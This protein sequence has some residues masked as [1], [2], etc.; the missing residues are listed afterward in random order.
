MSKLIRSDKNTESVER[1]PFGGCNRLLNHF[2]VIGAA[3][4]EYESSRSDRSERDF[5]VAVA[6]VPI[7]VLESYLEDLLSLDVSID[8]L[9]LSYEEPSLLS[10]C[11]AIAGMIFSVGLGIF[12]ASTGASLFLSLALTICLAF[13]FA[14]LWHFAPRA[15]IMRRMRLAQVLSRHISHR[16]GGDSDEGP[17]SGSLFLSS[18]LTAKRSGSTQGAARSLYS[19]VLH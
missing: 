19:D 3:L 5:G 11:F 15:G 13:P 1:H 6:F 4:L 7:E 16:R 8:R 17:G 14:A 2:Q 10:L 9:Y 12:A 18:L